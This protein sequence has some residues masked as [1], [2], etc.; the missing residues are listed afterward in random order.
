VVLAALLAGCEQPPDQPTDPKA[1]TGR[2]TVYTVN[3]PL[4]YFATR[5]GGDQVE[6]VFPAPA[7]GDPASWAPAGADIAAFQGAD[8]ILLN[9]AG[10]AG[11]TRLVSLPGEKLVDTAASFAD[12][13]IVVAAESSHRHGD[14]AEHSHEAKTAFTTW[15]DP[16]QAI[17][18][19]TAIRDAMTARRPEAAGAFQAGFDALAAD[20]AALDE[21]FA[22][23]FATLGDTPVVFSHPVYQYLQR[24]YG[25]N[26]IA[27]HWEPDQVPGDEQFQEL[28]QKLVR[29]PA[30]LLIWEAD[31]EPASV[32]ALAAM[33]VASATLDPCANR[34][35][36]GD[37]LGVM[38]QNVANLRAAL[39]SE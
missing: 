16:R 5:I 19:A 9:G 1:P 24:R 22:A 27:V 30:R 20:L 25:V 11:W 29:H 34:P 3:Y 32:K 6:V 17:A 10:Y 2:L 36:T 8:L 26:G 21:Q 23:V 15:L 4:A 7:D 39:E 37:Y 35:A 31:P 33:T 12:R 28:A 18:Q 38:Q 14:G 13:Y